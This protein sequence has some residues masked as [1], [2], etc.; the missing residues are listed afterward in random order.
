MGAHFHRC[1]GATRRLGR[2]QISLQLIGKRGGVHRRAAMARPAI[3][4]GAHQGGGAAAG[5]R[6]V[7]NQMGGGGFAVGAGDPDQRQLIAGVIPKRGSQAA[8]GRRHRISDHQHRITRSRWFLL[9]RIGPITAAVAP[10]CRA[11]RQKLPPSTRSPASPQTGCRGGCAGVAAE[12]RHHRV[13]QLL[14]NAQTG[15]PNQE[16]QARCLS[17]HAARRWWPTSFRRNCRC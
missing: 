9:G 7:L 3:G 4:Q 14:R 11:A 15:I 2:R 8:S 5:Q 13:G 16:M 10:C 12:V 6:Q 1:H 17:S